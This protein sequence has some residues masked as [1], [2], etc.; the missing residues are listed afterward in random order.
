[1]SLFDTTKLPCPLCGTETSFNAVHSVNVDRRPELRDQILEGTFQQEACGACGKTFRMDPQFTYVDLGRRQWIAVYGRDELD[2]WG[3]L[4]GEV[5]ELYDSAFGK[6]APPLAQG[7]AVG[8]T[9]RLLFGWP[10]LWEKLSLD[11]HG[12]DEVQMQLFKTGLLRN[13]E[14][15]PLGPGSEL[16]FLEVPPDRPD[17][18]SLAWLDSDTADFIEGLLVPRALYDEVALRAE[19]WQP[20]RSELEGRLFLDMQRLIT[21]ST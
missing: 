12:L 3:M 4:E 11:D 10:A 14:E 17:Q 9:P 13:M 8:V 16:R 19:A 1:M 6:N 18:L 2:Q 20:L 5:S 15:S 21:A 7:L